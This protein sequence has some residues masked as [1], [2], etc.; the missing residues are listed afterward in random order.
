MAEQ[1]R[2]ITIDTRLNRTIGA[3][4]DAAVKERLPSFS[5]TR[6]KVEAMA[7]LYRP[8]LPWRP[9]VSEPERTEG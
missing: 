2:P 7:E 3:E 9:P 4:V 1:R 8:I 5:L 6:E